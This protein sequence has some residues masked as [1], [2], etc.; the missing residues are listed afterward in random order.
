MTGK[1]PPAPW[2]N[3]IVGVGEEAPDQ[4]LANPQNWRTHPA[5]QRDA[6]RGSL[7]E[8][9]WVQQVMVNR[10]TGFV[11]DGHARIEEALSRHEATVPVLYV[12]LDPD[13]EALVLATLDP[14]GAMATAN[15]ARLAELLAEISPPDAALAA[16]LAGMAARAG[17]APKAGLADPDDVPE[18]SDKPY[19][20]TGELWILGE[21]RLLCGDATNAQDVARLLDGATPTLLATDPPYGVSLDQTWR[22]G[23]K[24]T[25]LVRGRGANAGAER[26]PM[27]LAGPMGHPGGEDATRAPT[28]RHRRTVG[29]RNTSIS[30]DTRVDW[31]EAFALVPSLQVGYVWHA[32]VHAA[33]VAQ[34][35]ERI[36]YLI[37]AQVIWDK[38][39]FA[40]GRSWYHWSHEPCWV[41][42]KP[43]AKVPFYGER[44]QATVW[45][46]P[47][48]KRLALPTN[49]NEAAPEPRSLGAATDYRAAGL[50]RSQRGARDGPGP[51]F[52]PYR[53]RR[54]PARFFGSQL[55]DVDQPEDHHHDNDH[56]D[57]SDATASGVHF[58]LPFSNQ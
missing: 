2:R 16:L 26:P 46:A 24:G 10:R 9:G 42:R 43:G 55:D 56:A 47:S 12:D 11:V 57:D 33:E 14:I 23:V 18:L 7:S 13:E 36:G 53:V 38:G 17:I 48:P 51:S 39:L 30:G 29:H 21:H 52:G 25:A 45:R 31:S 50:A 49:R 40:M 6:L 3:R 54:S 4:L 19:V 35:L 41:V 1:V 44:N 28:R 58:D 22:D 27:M 5:P 20:R 32:G 37:V 34:G 15:G 8:V